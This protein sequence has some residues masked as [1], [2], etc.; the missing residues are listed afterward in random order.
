MSQILRRSSI[1]VLRTLRS[2]VRLQ[3]TVNSLVSKIQNDVL[4]QPSPL[5]A[6]LNNHKGP[7]ALPELV[8]LRSENNKATDSRS[9]MM[10]FLSGLNPE[11]LATIMTE[12]RS[13]LHLPSTQA[14]IV[15]ELLRMARTGDSQGFRNVLSSLDGDNIGPFA[16]KLVSKLSLT[17]EGGV[18][19]T[20]HHI[21]ALI[22]SHWNNPLLGAT[23][24]LGSWNCSLETAQVVV[25][26][27][28][29]K[30]PKYEELILDL[31]TKIGA[32]Y[33]YKFNESEVNQIMEKVAQV[34]HKSQIIK[35]VTMLLIE[36]AS[37]KERSRH[38]KKIY[39]IILNDAHTKNIAGVYLNWRNVMDEYPTI[40]DHDLRVVS[41]VILS[42]LRSKQYHIIAQEI[43][44]QIPESAYAHPFL[45]Q[46]L[47]EYAFKRNDVGL[48][49]EIVRRLRQPVS[50]EVLSTLLKLNMRLGDYAGM[51]SVMQQITKAGGMSQKDYETIVHGLLK[52][53]DFLD[54]VTFTQNIPVHLSQGACLKLINHLINTKAQ[55]EEPEFAVVE[56]LLDKIQ[57]SAPVGSRQGK[58]FWNMVGSIY[59]KYLVKNFGRQGIR[60]ARDIYERSVKDYTLKAYGAS[61][62]K[63]PLLETANISTNPF[64]VPVNRRDTIRLLIDDRSSGII[65]RTIMDAAKR[66]KMTAV[67]NWALLSLVELG[68]TPTEV[69][70]DV[71]RKFNVHARKI[72]LRE[73]DD[74]EKFQDLWDQG[75]IEFVKDG[76][77]KDLSD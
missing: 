56:S 8:I 28:L 69:K 30:N 15:S 5:T 76:V 26:S 58:G 48:A 52:R 59:I 46:P 38:V 67:V 20:M 9:N 4:P 61:R 14:L 35:R 36:H 71:T 39:N 7:L 32:R 3:S 66:L 13:N 10:S 33:A 29:T 12:I 72:G 60:D 41:T 1:P 47:L 45:V 73:W 55:W 22:C 77:L 17:P 27:L 51:E 63:D 31:L 57:A 16:A 62:P 68:A 11:I 23:V 65:V 42:L 21:L 19:S 70:I 75:T 37:F 49:N 43:V 64:I 50:K 2:A 40:L 25:R 24:V 74:E 54:A 18:G 6:K 53:D 34:P 44:E